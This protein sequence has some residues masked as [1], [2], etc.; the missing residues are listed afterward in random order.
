MTRI[1]A[2]SCV[3]LL[4]VLAL[5]AD[6]PATQPAKERTTASGLKIADLKSIDAPLVSQAG[7]EV[8]VHY[9]G[10]LQKDNS[11]F[12]SSF[13]RVDNTTQMPSPIAFVLGRGSVIPGWEEGLMGMRVGE[14][15]RLIIPPQLAYGD[16]GAG[17]RIP[18][19]ST[20]VFD[21][22]LVGIYRPEK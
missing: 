17:D 22:E 7:D 13:D 19:G 9:P 6:Q 10:R 16:R 1:A 18:P 5:A 15:R 14:K 3:V 8:W 20:L 4:A 2:V 11:K 12:D 21:V